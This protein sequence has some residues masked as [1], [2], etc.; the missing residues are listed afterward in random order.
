[1]GP[2]NVSR[3]VEIERKYSV[4][5]GATMPALDGV[6]GVLAAE[7]H[8]VAH[9]DAV[10]VDTADRVLLAAGIAVRR[11]TGGHDA[12]WHVKLR[13][14]RGRTELHAPIDEGDPDAFPEA[15]AAALRT[16]L[17]GRPLE[18]I[19]RIRTERHAVVVTDE[20][21]GAVEV[22]DDRVSA[23][24]VGAGV[25]R[26]WREWEAEQVEDSK[27]CEA[28]LDRLHLVLLGAGASPSESPAKIAQALGLVGER[29]PP[30]EPRTAGAVLQ[31]L[32][33]GHLEE[34]HR[35]V[36]SLV[37]D[38]DPDGATVHELRKVVRRAR[39]VLA[40]APVTGE[41]GGAVRAAL[42]DLGRRL[43]DARDPV[44]GARIAGELLDDLP[45]GTPGLEAAR[46]LLVDEP[47]A[48]QPQETA[49]LV[50]DLAGPGLLDVIA[51]LEAFQPDGPSADGPPK[52]LTALAKRTVRRARKRTGAGMSGDLDR[53]H[54]ARKAA[55]RAR[56]VVEELVAAG[57]LQ[58]GS[59]LARTARRDE[60]AQDALGDHRDLALLLAELPAA[61]ASLTAS[62][63]NAFA[64]GR[65]AETAE[66]ELQR[67]WRRAVRAVRRL[68]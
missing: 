15:F 12:G 52:L 60:R 36:Q 25:L 33:A 9:L 49:R 35:G 38:G 61:S 65:I 2:V 6:D 63:G 14:P 28:L 1:M 16:R 23:T 11:R 62:G 3:A 22:V 50:E 40:L 48:R 67:R 56:F 29:T 20:A 41:A 4:P 30:D 39:S 44:V 54:R 55:K 68:A 8:P 31:R 51:A 37:L 46:A 34:L 27:E 26:V 17:R 57:V 24:D 13:G 64:V 19:A 58:P 32:V 42:G 66:R 43:G 10:Y 7:P 21:G 45:D 18:P 5:E 47:L 59:G 53:M